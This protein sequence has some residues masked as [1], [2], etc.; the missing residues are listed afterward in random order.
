MVIDIDESIDILMFQ[1]F[2]SLD[3]IVSRVQAYYS[4]CDQRNDV[5]NHLSYTESSAFFRSFL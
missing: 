3:I 1:Q 5:R 4:G 2:I